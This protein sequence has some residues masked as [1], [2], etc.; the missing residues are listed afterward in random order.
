MITIKWNSI[1]IYT[2]T[3]NTQHLCNVKNNNKCFV[4]CLVACTTS[5]VTKSKSALSIRDDSMRH[6]VINTGWQINTHI[7]KVARIWASHCTPN[8]NEAQAPSCVYPS[9]YHVCAMPIMT[10]K[11]WCW[12]S[13]IIIILLTYTSIPTFEQYQILVHDKSKLIMPPP[14]PVF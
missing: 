13:N 8:Q 7:D 12:M 10:E 9:M 6:Y 5:K 3:S 4:I 2:T 14:F 1:I 11:Q